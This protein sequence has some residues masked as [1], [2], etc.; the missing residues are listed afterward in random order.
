[1]PVPERKE[2]FL[3]IVVLYFNVAKFIHLLCT[4]SEYDLKVL[5]ELHYINF[6]LIV[7]RQW[8]RLIFVISLTSISY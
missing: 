2:N 5:S 1:M 3:K 4:S 6:F 7:S 8:V